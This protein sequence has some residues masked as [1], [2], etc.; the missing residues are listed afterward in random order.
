MSARTMRRLA[1]TIE[2]E[3]IMNI[4]QKIQAAICMAV[5]ALACMTVTPAAKAQVIATGALC[6]GIGTQ[7]YVPNIT[8]APTNTAFSSSGVFSCLSSSL[9][10]MVGG[11]FTVTGNGVYSCLG[12]TSFIG[13][14][15]L[16]WTDNNG[17]VIGTSTAPLN[18][19][20]V[21]IPVGSLL[22]ARGVIDSGDPFEAANATVSLPALTIQLTGCLGPGIKNT[23][24][25]VFL[26]IS[27]L[28]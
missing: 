12:V 17:N 8:L 27:S 25:P 6:T 18:S 3:F 9:P 24:S 2:R 1:I 21:N 20:G 28:L 14:L 16:N 26:G 13:E 7:T 4:R 23:A 19:L 5:V 11:N 22:A 10:G 15:Q